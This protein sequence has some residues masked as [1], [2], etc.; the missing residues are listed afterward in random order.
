MAHL[1]PQQEK[2]WRQGGVALLVNAPFLPCARIYVEKIPRTV[3]YKVALAMGAN[4][5]A[6]DLTE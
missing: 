2:L 3:F 4:C 6:G 1:L 5:I